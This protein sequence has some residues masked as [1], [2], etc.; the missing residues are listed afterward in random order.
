[1]T[2]TRMFDAVSGIDEGL[3]DRCLAEKPAHSS[4]GTGASK[5]KLPAAKYRFAAAAAVLTAVMVLL[6][7]SLP[8]ILHRSRI[9]PM[10][11]SDGFPGEGIKLLAIGIPFSSVYV[12][13]LAEND[14]DRIS[15][16]NAS[17]SFYKPK[18]DDL[19]YVGLWVG[20]NANS[21]F[22]FDENG[23]FSIYIVR[24]NNVLAF[25]GKGWY[26]IEEGLLKVYLEDESAYGEAKITFG[27]EYIV[28][29]TE[30]EPG[31]HF[32]LADREAYDFTDGEYKTNTEALDFRNRTWSLP[33]E[34]LELVFGNNN[35][36]TV[37]DFSSGERTDIP[38]EWD[39]DS[40]TVSFKDW[41]GGSD[42][43]LTGHIEN[44]ALIVGSGAL[45][46]EF[47]IEDP[48]APEGTLQTGVLFTGRRERTEEGW[49]VI[50]FEADGRY[51]ITVS[52]P[53]GSL[54]PEKFYYEGAYEYDGKPPVGD[55]G[56]VHAE[57][58]GSAFIRLCPGEGDMP[59]SGSESDLMLL[60][61]LIDSYGMRENGGRLW[62]EGNEITIDINPDPNAEEG[63]EYSIPLRPLL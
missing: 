27:G 11:H 40:N 29:S 15:P 30:D 19:K 14:P 22:D 44:E 21:A 53:D 20:V 6:A 51:I 16:E 3:I 17:Y 33:E 31:M 52:D 7:F 61:S 38:Y 28:L 58:V 47:I 39:P 63:H 26:C 35:V 13:T 25:A 43:I 8:G 2:D 24:E 45:R 12:E 55:D 60:I 57:S 54:L 4:A 41:H 50:I 46:Y 5:I 49:F 9:D 37:Y 32:D 36:C 23:A 1:M 34:N 48:F 62:F 56:L 18:G 42:L 10:P 59:V